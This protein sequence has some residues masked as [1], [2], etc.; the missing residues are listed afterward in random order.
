MQSKGVHQVYHY[1]DDFVTQGPPSSDVCS[2]NLA[3]I[4]DVCKEL[5][6][7]LAVEKVEGP[8][9]TITFLGIEIDTMAGVLRLPQD[10]LQRLLSMLQEWDGKKS[11]TRKELQSLVGSLQHACTVVKPGRAF[12]RRM[13]DLLRVTHRPYHHT[14]MN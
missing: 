7:P 5:G 12:L 9:S 8:T 11:C 13:I 1:L 2:W 4:L 10:K 3:L 14:R 6:V